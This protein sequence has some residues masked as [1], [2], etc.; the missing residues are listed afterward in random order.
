VEEQK[1]VLNWRLIFTL[2][3]NVLVGF[4]WMAMF[5]EGDHVTQRQL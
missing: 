3:Y 4:P 2:R 1:E 5:M